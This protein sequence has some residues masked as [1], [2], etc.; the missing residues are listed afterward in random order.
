MIVEIIKTNEIGIFSELFLGIAIIYIVLFGTFTSYN[1]KYKFPLIQ[2]STIFLGILI[3]GMLCFLS[4]NDNLINSNYL[5]FNYSVNND[6]LSVSSK[7]IIGVVS[8]FFLLTIQQYLTN[9]K[10]NHFEYILIIL[11][12]ILGIFL[13]CSSNDLIVTYL[14]I[15][16]QSL[17][18]YVLAVSQ[19]NSSFSVEVGLKYF[20]LGAF[21]S[22]LFLFGS[23]LIY[24]V[25]G[26]LN[27]EDFKSLFFC[28]FPLKGALLKNQ[29]S[30][31]FNSTIIECFNNKLF[32]FFAQNFFLYKSTMN[33]L[34]PITNEPIIRFLNFYDALAI[35]QFS[36]IFILVS[37]F[38][39]LA[40]APFHIWSPDI[41]EGSPTS[42]AIFFAIIPKLAIFVLLLRINYYSFF[43]FIDNWRYYVVIIAIFS[44][45]VGSFVGL[46]QRK[47]KSL[48]AY[49][50]VSHMGYLLISFSTGTVEGIQM[51]FNYIIIYMITGFCIWSILITTKLKNNYLKK[52][53][54]DLGDLTLFVKSNKILTFV[55]AVSL[56]SIAGLPPII[57]FFVKFGIFLVT[58]NG[59]MYFTALLALIFSVISTFYYIRIIKVLYFEQLLV[60][61]LYFPIKTQKIF[62][63]ILLFYFL[64]FLF[65]NPTFL[66]LFSYKISL[67]I[68]YI[69]SSV[70]I[71]QQPS[72]LKV[73]GSNPLKCY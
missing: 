69:F 67:L 71:E 16:L 48:I 22:G 30:I 13:L 46:E 10:I 3:I 63:S 8:I 49:S 50:S 27:F 51:L 65:I 6:Y 18:F 58:V 70:W 72:K 60:G 40:L 26:S 38:F 43:G 1:K 29:E 20:I 28:V 19:K 45:I 64:I 56:F 9:Q 11:F 73:I 55:M 62:I 2:N 47:L 42:S 15:E 52:E 36:L 32:E 59:F 68:F 57:G 44:I 33:F 4:F 66:Y 54:K 53:N 25:T 39:K 21:S 17:S 5:S 7:L 41:Y 31:I 37:L 24:G 35:I 14:A 12:S 61:K 23:S 34:N